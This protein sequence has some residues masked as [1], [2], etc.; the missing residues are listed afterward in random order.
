[1]WCAVASISASVSRNRNFPELP[2]HR[3][4]RSERNRGYKMRC[5][6]WS[7]Q[8]ASLCTPGSEQVTQLTFCIRLRS[9]NVRESGWAL[10]SIGKKPS[11]VAQLASMSSGN[12]E[13]QEKSSC[14]KVSATTQQ[15]CPKERCL[16]SHACFTAQLHVASCMS[17]LAGP[18]LSYTNGI[19]L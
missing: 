7:Q 15:P 11:L 1:M 10:V 12:C 6:M 9:S 14:G 19:R 4:M 5:D 17:P 13:P 16:T 3:A 18:V 2:R 8:V